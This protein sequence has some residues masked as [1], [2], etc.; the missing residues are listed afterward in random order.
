[1]TPIPKRSPAWTASWPRSRPA[2]RPWSTLNWLVH[3]AGAPVLG[4]LLHGRLE[5]SHESLDTVGQAGIYLRAAF[6]EHGALEPRREADRITTV[7][8]P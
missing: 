5:I 7:D 4:E 3:G 2:E 6:V 1:M 8:R